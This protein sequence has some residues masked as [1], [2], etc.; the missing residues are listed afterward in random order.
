MRTSVSVEDAALTEGVG[1]ANSREARRD[2]TDEKAWADSEGRSALTILSE[3]PLDLHLKKH[4]SRT[5]AGQMRPR[6]CPPREPL[7]RVAWP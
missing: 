6:D 7:N 3:T 2:D 4:T 1:P 5:R